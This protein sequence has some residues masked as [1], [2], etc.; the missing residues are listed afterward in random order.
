MTGFYR[1]DL[2]A[3]LERNESKTW[4]PICVWARTTFVPDTMS[5]TFQASTDYYAPPT[6]REYFL[7]LLSVPDGVTGA[8]PAGT[9][10]QLSPVGTLIL[11]LPTHRTTDGLT[12]YQ[13]AFTISEAEPAPGDMDND[14]D[15]DQDD[16]VVFEGC[17][18]G[19]EGTAGPDCTPEQADR[20]DLNHNN[21]VDLADFRLFSLRFTGLLTS[22]ATYVGAAGC[23]ECHQTEHNCYVQTRHGSAFQTLVDDGEEENPSCLPC[24]TVGFGAI[25]GFV[26][27]ETTPELANVQCENCHGPASHHADDADNVG[28]DVDLGSLL[29]GKCHQ[30]CHGMC[31]DYYH[32]HYEQ[33]STSK[34][35]QALAEIWYA[36]DYE[37][38]CLECH[39]TDYRLAPEEAKPGPSDVRY[40]LE[41]V[42]CHAPRGSA[43]AYQLRMEPG[44]LCAQCHTMGDVIPGQEPDQAQTEFMYGV[45]GYA[46]DGT[47]LDD[48]YPTPFTS[49]ENQCAFCHVHR[50]PYVEPDQPANSGHTFECNMRACSSCHTEAEA[51]ERVALVQEEIEPRL[52]TIGHYLNPLHPLYVDPATLGPAE[53]VRYNIAKFD[54]E[55]VQADRS[56]GAHNANF[57]R[58]L[59]EEAELFFGIGP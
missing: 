3:P 32:P 34:H 5:V 26:D 4:E 35:S 55:F 40:S 13:F 18:A 50:E 8:P 20:S 46:L 7:E 1:N 10:W 25:S 52:L 47:P 58:R 17:F 49:F 15:V 9:V 54:Y 31:G 36:A 28:L 24:H 39:S 59:L 57:A 44:S 11:N 37:E 30:S 6:N 41:C 51:A 2:R 38:S 22:P 12:G 19:P 33:W 21:R 14:G 48:L 23:I 56:F 53:L 29:C 42:A 45:G 16:F 27:I 43:N